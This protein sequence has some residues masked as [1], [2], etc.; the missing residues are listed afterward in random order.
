M[1]YVLVFGIGYDDSN[2]KSETF[3]E[4]RKKY[5]LKL[6]EKYKQFKGRYLEG[7][8]HVEFPNG[9]PELEQ[10][11]RKECESKNYIYDIGARLIYSEKDIKAAKFV[12]LCCSGVYD[13]DMDDHGN[14]F[15]TYREVLCE[16][17][18]R[19][20][21]NNVPNPYLVYDKRVKSPRDILDAANGITIISV[22]A[23]ELLRSKIEPWVDSGQV[24]IVDKGK[25]PVKTDY[26]YVW[27]RPRFEVGPF[28]N[29][30]VKQVCDKCKQPTEIR[31]DY[32]G[33][34]FDKEK[35][36][37]ESFKNTKAPIVLAGNWFG[38]VTPKQTSNH[39]R[40]VFISTNLHEKIR[41][42]KLKGFLKA[43]R[44]IHSADASENSIQP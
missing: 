2:W 5:F 24:Q 37:V 30:R 14:K 8:E 26:E 31:I 22:L 18:G 3:R 20:N 12:P 16:Y 29:A 1:K 33:D 27:I 38:E 32:S 39:T 40:D 13:A 17:C 7:Y 44:I 19:T 11:L 34:I 23:F 6:I 41:K 21:D 36:I 43:D 25:R 15:N 4:D 35:W 28:V 10:L 9:T 42:L